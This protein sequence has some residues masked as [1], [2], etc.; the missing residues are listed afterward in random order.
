MPPSNALNHQWQKEKSYTRSSQAVF[1]PG[2]LVQSC[3]PSEY[4]EEIGLSN[5][6]SSLLLLMYK[7]VPSTSFDVQ[8]VV[9]PNNLQNFGFDVHNI[10]RWCPSTYFNSVT[11]FGKSLKPACCC[12]L[13]VRSKSYGCPVMPLVTGLNAKKVRW[14]Q[15]SSVWTAITYWT[16]LTA[17]FTSYYNFT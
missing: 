2:I 15:W 17:V 4:A 3:L 13:G 7:D 1:Q 5:I 11:R 14:I 12:W 16:L 10:C 6:L 8:N 9:L